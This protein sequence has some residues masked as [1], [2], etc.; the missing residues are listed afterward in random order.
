MTEQDLMN[1]EDAAGVLSL[2]A[3]TVRRLIRQG[4]IP[5]VQ[6]GGPG[7]RVRIRR[8]DLDRL[9]EAQPRSAA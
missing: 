5:V 6:L 3:P 2:S 8:R 9:L 7:H 4:V 1:V